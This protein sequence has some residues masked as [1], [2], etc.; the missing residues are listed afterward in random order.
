MSAELNSLPVSPVSQVDT[1]ALGQEGGK[2][3]KKY[4]GRSYIV[5]TGS[6]GG[7]YILVKGRKI[8]V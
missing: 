7:K 4:N 3:H 5:R 6:R 2:R 8:Y 1:P